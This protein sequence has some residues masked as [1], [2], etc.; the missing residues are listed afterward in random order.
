MDA[1][2][3][4]SRRG[5]ELETMAYTASNKIDDG[6]RSSRHMIMEVLWESWGPV[7][8]SIDPGVI[9]LVAHLREAYAAQVVVCLPA[10]QNGSI[11]DQSER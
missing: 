8:C 2:V 10:D 9:S 3:L 5:K 4:Q 1:R 11:N 7:Q 6:A